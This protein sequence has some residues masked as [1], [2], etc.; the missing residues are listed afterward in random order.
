MQH[1][2]VKESIRLLE[3][4]G[5]DSGE[6]TKISTSQGLETSSCYDV[7][8]CHIC[9]EAIICWLELNP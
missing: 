7:F 8:S 3:A 2:N 6:N 1:H 9:V 4:E 5:F